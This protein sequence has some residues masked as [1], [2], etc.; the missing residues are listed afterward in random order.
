MGAFCLVRGIHKEH[1]SAEFDQVSQRGSA[2]IYML[3][4]LT[5][6]ASHRLISPLA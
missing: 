2:S 4:V 5:L 3:I 6:H 1:T